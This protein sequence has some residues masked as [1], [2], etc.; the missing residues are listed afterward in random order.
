MQ[1]IKVDRPDAQ[2]VI[3][4]VEVAEDRFARDAP[5]LET[6]IGIERREAALCNDIQLV[7]AISGADVLPK[8][9]LTAAKGELIVDA[10]V[11]AGCIDGIA[12]QLAETVDQG[13]GL[14]LRRFPAKGAAQ[15]EL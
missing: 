9:G 14:F 13:K 2:I 4:G 5:A 10:A 15:N 1:Q 6:E 12:A 7:A 8:A 11:G 3:A